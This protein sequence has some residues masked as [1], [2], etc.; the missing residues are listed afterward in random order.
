[1][2]QEDYSKKNMALYE[3]K[4]DYLATYYLKKDSK[5]IC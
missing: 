5:Y 3:G 4:K 2:N 1:M